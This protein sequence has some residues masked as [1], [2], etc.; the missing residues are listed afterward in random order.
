MN[1]LISR[2]SAE[3]CGFVRMKVDEF[4]IQQGP[5][6]PSIILQP[7]PILTKERYM[8]TF[9]LMLTFALT[10]SSAFADGSGRPKSDSGI[11][12]GQDSGKKG[13]R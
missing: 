11:K 12:Q 1:S 8:K 5:V 13:G 6:L 2:K 7:G 4:I 9:I 10:L 3:F